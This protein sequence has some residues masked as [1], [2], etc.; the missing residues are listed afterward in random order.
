MLKLDNIEDLEKLVS[1]FNRALEGRTIILYVYNENEFIFYRIEP[2]HRDY[3][4]TGSLNILDK[5]LTEK[6]I[7]TFF[8]TYYPDYLELLKKANKQIS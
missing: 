1:Q 4:I 7:R 3:A 2:Q 6:D 5:K 8:G